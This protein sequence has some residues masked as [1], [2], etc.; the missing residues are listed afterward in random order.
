MPGQ[1]NES[2]PQSMG[3]IGRN[4]YFPSGT[5]F[6]HKGQ[7]LSVIPAANLDTFDFP[8]RG[9]LVFRNH[10]RMPAQV[11]VRERSFTSP[12]PG[13]EGVSLQFAGTQTYAA[14]A[15]GVDFTVLP[16][17]VRPPA[18]IGYSCG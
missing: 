7:D 12:S 9:R 14:I 6:D 16:G 10:Q 18:G 5:V 17:K 2:L 3:F 8:S 11:S 15:T 1:R 4:L 13:A